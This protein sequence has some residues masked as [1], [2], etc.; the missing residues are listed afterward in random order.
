MT[1]GARELLPP[2]VPRAFGQVEAELELRGL[3]CALLDNAAFVQSASWQLER[4]VA[5]FAGAYRT[6]PRRTTARAS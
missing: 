6:V 4:S 2:C 3:D 5:A 1:L